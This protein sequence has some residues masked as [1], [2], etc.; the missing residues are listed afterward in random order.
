MAEPLPGSGILQKITNAILV[1]PDGTP[2]Q[3]PVP[4]AGPKAAP[5][6][7]APLPKRKGN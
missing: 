1:D 7:A 6:E 5:E 4:T 3:I 2:H